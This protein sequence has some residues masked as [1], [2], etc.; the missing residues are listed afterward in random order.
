MKKADGRGMG[1]IGTG[2]SLISRHDSPIIKAITR[3]H[4]SVELPLGDIV[5]MPSKHAINALAK[6]AY[7]SDIAALKDNIR[8]CCQ[9]Q[10]TPGGRVLHLAGEGREQIKHYLVEDTLSILSLSYPT[11]ENCQRFGG[12]PALR[13]N[14]MPALVHPLQVMA[15]VAAIEAPINEDDRLSLAS[16][17]KGGLH[18]ILED[19]EDRSEAMRNVK[20]RA[21]AGH[22]EIEFTNRRKVLEHLVGLYSEYSEQVANRIA[23]GLLLLTRA[24]LPVGMDKADYYI[25]EYLRGLYRDVSCAKAKGEDFHSNAM[26]IRNIGNEAE[27]MRLAG[28]LI[29]KGLPQVLAWK[30]DAWVEYHRL[31]A[32]LEDL[33]SLFIGEQRYHGIMDEIMAPSAADLD[34][35]EAGFVLTGSR[36]FNYRLMATMPPSGSPV[37]THY[38]TVREGK[39][40][41]EIEIPFCKNLNQAKDIIQSGFHGVIDEGIMQAPN[42]IQKRLG[43]GA[44]YSFEAK[45]GWNLQNKMAECRRKYDRMLHD[46]E[47]GPALLGFDRSRFA[48]EARRKWGP[49]I[50]SGSKRL[51]GF[52]FYKVQVR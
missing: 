29:Q 27:M 16:V 12:A 1:G 5:V 8:L 24:K 45:E 15:G 3:V 39:P 14:G 37:L 47:M 52:K 51:E 25:F 42:L 23:K 44:V 46:G 2:E 19:V 22:R 18:D 49:Q 7:S 36:K 35:F 38:Q 40:I 43:S 31:L 34:N 17:V 33:L 32:R 50:S 6:A 28:N 20:F 26:S 4:E 10:V 13:T 9:Y 21:V 48:Q 11:V 41:S 30:K